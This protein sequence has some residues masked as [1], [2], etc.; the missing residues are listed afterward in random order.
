MPDTLL[1]LPLFYIILLFSV[2]IH[3]CAHAI[4]AYKLGDPT[5]YYQGRITLN[6]IPHIDLVWTIIIPLLTYLGGGF[7]FGGAKPVPINPY[8]FRHPEKGMMLS[9]IAGP[10]SNFA[11]ASLGFLAFFLSVKVLP[12]RDEFLRFNIY[13]FTM[14]ILL[15]ILLGIFNLIPIPPLDGSRVLRYFVPWHMKETLDRIEPF[16]FII[17]IIFVMSGGTLFIGKLLNFIQHLLFSIL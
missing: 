17:I 4:A 7:I 10:L 3:E 13:I 12:I 11:L 1:Y 9:S 2:I 8:N 14:M 16:G 5:A 15:N 6:P